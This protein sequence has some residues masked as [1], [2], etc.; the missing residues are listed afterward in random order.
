MTELKTKRRPRGIS[1]R[2]DFEV[3]KSIATSS[4]E[5]RKAADK[6]KTEALRDARLRAQTENGDSAK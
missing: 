4:E 3:A 1:A 2:G 5:A 6:R